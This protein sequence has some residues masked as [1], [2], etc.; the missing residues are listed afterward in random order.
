M[1]DFSVR[2]I[3]PCS[4]HR[5]NCVLRAD[6]A[7]INGSRICVVQYNKVYSIEGRNRFTTDAEVL[8][9]IGIPEF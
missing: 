4:A 7:S 9:A 1:R 3:L 2:H 5:S 8:A 6:V